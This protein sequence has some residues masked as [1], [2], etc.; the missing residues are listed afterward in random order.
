MLPITDKRYKS[1]YTKGVISSRKSK[2]DRQ[3]N[4]QRE[5]GQK[6]KQQSTKHYTETKERATPVALKQGVNS[7]P[8]EGLAVP[9]PH[10]IPTRASSDMDIA[11]DTNMSKYKTHGI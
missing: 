5:K 3:H 7:G 8:P 10:V 2:R 11:L 1:E 9:T 4:G 6:N